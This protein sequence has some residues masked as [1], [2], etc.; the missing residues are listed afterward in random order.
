[1]PGRL[2]SNLRDDVMMALRSPVPQRASA[3][4]MPLPLLLAL[5][6]EQ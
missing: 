1:M 3:C 4:L 5:M 6:Q 2:L